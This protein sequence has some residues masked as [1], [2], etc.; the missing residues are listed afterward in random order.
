[1]YRSRSSALPVS[2]AHLYSARSTGPK[3]SAVNVMGSLRNDF[4]GAAE[5]LWK[6]PELRQTIL[7]VQDGLLIVHVN[8]GF[9]SDRRQGGG[10]D[11]DE[12][13]LRV[14]GQEMA[15]TLLTPLPEAVR[16][17]VE[18]LDERRTFGDLY[19]FRCP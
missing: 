14:F 19:V 10:K 5:L 13:P 2:I 9:E 3:L 12:V 7:Y 6:I 1:M 4:P 8:T 11:I 18:L 15:T 16:V 17:L